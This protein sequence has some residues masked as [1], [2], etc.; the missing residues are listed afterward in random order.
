MSSVLF[1]WFR[2]L[3][4]IRGSNSGP[5]DFLELRAYL[6]TKYHFLN[7][8]KQDHKIADLKVELLSR[9]NENYVKVTQKDNRDINSKKA[10]DHCYHT[11]IC[12]RHLCL[13]TRDSNLC[14]SQKQC[15]YITLDG[16][17]AR[18]D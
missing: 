11:H 12:P 17:Q 5:L 16:S 8:R 4:H 1:H 15:K 7:L 13:Y 18:F 3:P 2:P 9:E 14:P 10:T 6:E